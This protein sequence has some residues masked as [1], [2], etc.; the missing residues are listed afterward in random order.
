MAA[1]LR[2]LDLF[3]GIG[4]FSLGL[5]RAGMRTVAFCEADAAARRVLRA[6]WGPTTLIYPDVRTLSGERLRQD[7]VPAPDLV[8][9]G[10]PC[11]GISLLG[12]ARGARGLRGERSALWWEMLRLV[13]ELRPGWVLAENVPALRSR[14]LDRVLGG[15]AAVG[16]DAEWH[17]VPASRV[18]APH[19]RDRLWIVA[20]PA[21]AGLA[22]A[23]LPGAPGT[24]R[25]AGLGAQLAECARWPAEPA[26]G[27]V[28]DG[29]SGPVDGVRARVRDRIRCLGNA[30]VPAIPEAIGRAILAAE[31][32]AGPRSRYT[33]SPTAMVPTASTAQ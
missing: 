21:R 30:V 25:L 4:G 28:A 26:L 3:S 18:G 31:G 27:R 19:R 2:V 1:T 15:L 33:G 10:F 5:G 6:H 9:G 7:G 13:A 17:C 20:Y 23:G 24:P 14:G 16:Y 12:P 11:Q 22:G 29:L 32:Y 8:C